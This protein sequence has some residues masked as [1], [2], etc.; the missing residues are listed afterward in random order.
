MAIISRHYLYF[1]L[2]HSTNFMD[3]MVP[4]MPRLNKLFH[5]HTY[6]EKPPYRQKNRHKLRRLSY[7]C[8]PYIPLFVNC[9]NGNLSSDSTPSH[10]GCASNPQIHI[11]Q[12]HRFFYI[13]HSSEILRNLIYIFQSLLSIPDLWGKTLPSL[14]R[15]KVFYFDPY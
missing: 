10:F 7:R 12:Y 1:Y 3:F 8:L 5:K 6:C 2:F 11:L 13:L 9:Q 4:G 15:H 14:H